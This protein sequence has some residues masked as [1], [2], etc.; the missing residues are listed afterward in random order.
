MKEEWKTIYLKN[1]NNYIVSNKGNVKNIKTKYILKQSLRNG[2][3][4]VSLSNKNI[5]KTFNV[6]TLVLSSFIGFKK[7]YIINHIDGNKSNNCL[8]NLE[9]V[10]YKQ[11]SKHALKQKL[12]IPFT[13]KVNQYDK[14]GNLLNTFDS[15]K[16]ASIKT[17]AN[18]RH[19]SSVCRGKRKTTGGY[20][21]KYTDKCNILN[22]CD[23]TIVKNFPNYKI[24]KDGKIFSIRSKRYLK[25]KIQ[26]NGY[27]CIKLCN[28]GYQKDKYIHKLVAETFIKNT[29][30]K[31]YVNH[32]DGNK[33]NNNINNLEWVTH[34]EN[35]LHSNRVLSNIYDIPIAVYDNKKKIKEYKSIR[36]ASNDTNI[37]NSRILVACKNNSILKK[38]KWKFITK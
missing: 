12:L 20:V 10:T 13:R 6:H 7:K 32:I 35:M 21:W 22:D 34:S 29:K 2:Y 9:W 37:D 24:T 25:Q 11:N 38:F 8:E 36:D 1:F 4:S 27:H 23:G 30:N 14:N 15:I 26:P 17:G 31:K 28:N 33:S 5:K 19:I 18:D 16:I 3:Q